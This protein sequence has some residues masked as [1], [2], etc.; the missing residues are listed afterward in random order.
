MAAN[1]GNPAVPNDAAFRGHFK[2]PDLHQPPAQWGRLESSVWGHRT[3]PWP[4]RE[5]E[6]F[7]NSHRPHQGIANAR[8]LHPLPVPITDLEQIT[9]LD[10][11]KRERLGG[12]LHEYQHAA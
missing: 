9:R 11:R 3:P 12:I 1:S 8:P 10:I 5:F 2:S 4:L 6:E 7:Y